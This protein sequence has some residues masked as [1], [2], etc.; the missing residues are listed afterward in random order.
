MNKSKFQ[1]DLMGQAIASLIGALLLAL[2]DFS[3]FYYYDYYLKL[4]VW[5]WV[6][7]GSGIIPSI[8]ILFGMG[9]LLYSLKASVT[10]LRTEDITPEKLKENTEQSIRGAAFT[11]V[12]AFVGAIVFALSSLDTDWWLGGGFYGAFLGGL[13]T[14]YLGKRVLDGLDS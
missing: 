10:S 7:L 5:G 11:A 13:V 2:D 9:G 12:L 6:Y 14:V 3:G 8:L 4:E 1:T